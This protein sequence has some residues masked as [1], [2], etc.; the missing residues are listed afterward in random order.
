MPLC[1][2]VCSGLGGTEG[3]SKF[4]STLVGALPTI[5]QGA[6]QLDAL[7][8]PSGD[9][10]ALKKALSSEDAQI[11]QLKSLVAAFKAGNAEKIQSAETALEDSEAPLNQR[12]DVLGFTSCGS[13]SPSPST[14]TG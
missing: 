7:A 3:V 11:Q 12:F 6:A 2:G 1:H 10:V 9:D 13:G 5:E 8:Q 4:E 14:G